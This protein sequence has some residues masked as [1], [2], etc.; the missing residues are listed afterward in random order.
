VRKPTNPRPGTS[1]T[2][3][4]TTLERRAAFR[5]RVIA[6]DVERGE[7]PNG[8]TAELE[9]IR[10]PGGA[11]VVAVNADREVCLLRQYRHALDG[12]LWEL[13]A[14]KLDGGE[15]PLRAARRELAEEA[16]VT[17]RRWSGL[18]KFVSSPG[19]FTEVVHLF[20]ATRLAATRAQPEASEVF[21]VR[22]IA[23]DRAL[24]LAMKGEITDGKTVVGLARAA[25]RLR[26]IKSK[27]RKS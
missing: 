21:E 4:G 26:S 10:H 25:A 14:G 23:L 16:G 6:L 8:V 17:A 15:P 27:R 18:G 9:I 24:A 22:W 5:G 19:V 20:L 11:A 2:R 1:L 13:P 12:W 3:R 7:L